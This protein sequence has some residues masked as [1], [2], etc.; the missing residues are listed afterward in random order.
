M[1]GMKKIIPVVIGVIVLTILLAFLR[2]STKNNQSQ[3]GGIVK[4]SMTP[5]ASSSAR[6][7]DEALKNALNLY[8]KKKEEG[9]DFTNGPCLGMVAPDWVLDIAHNPHQSV[10]DEPEN[11]CADFREGRAHHFIE[12][13]PDGQ[14]IRSF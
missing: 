1:K 7:E 2:D 10:D 5:S 4:S 13:D 9:L 6:P 11:Q 3:S 12:L 8:I 14:L